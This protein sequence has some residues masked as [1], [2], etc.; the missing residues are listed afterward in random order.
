MADVSILS[1]LINGGAIVVTG[2]VSTYLIK[3]W[4]NARESTEEQ[5]KK[6]AL[7]AVEKSER[8]Q[9]ETAQ[10]IMGKIGDNKKFYSQTYTELKQQISDVKEELKAE[11]Q[12]TVALQKLTNGN[13]IRVDKELAVLKQAHEDRVESCGK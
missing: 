12:I 6:D 8:M 11:I 2:G 5:I 7:L 13:V 10:S 9:K 4:M 1:M 3:K